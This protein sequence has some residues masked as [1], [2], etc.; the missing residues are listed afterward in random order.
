M[1]SLVALLGAADEACRERAMAL[2]ARGAPADGAGG[3]LLVAGAMQ[4]ASSLVREQGEAQ[5]QPLRTLEQLSARLNAQTAVAIAEAQGA[6]EALCG[7]LAHAQTEAR[8]V[9]SRG[10]ASLQLLPRPLDRI[11]APRSVP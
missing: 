10:A 3:D 7:L 1:P 9:P 8:P 11:L 2:M 6:L 4:A 5:L